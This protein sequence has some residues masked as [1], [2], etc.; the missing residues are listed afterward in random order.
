ME[1]EEAGSDGGGDR[2][3][4]VA[5]V[6]TRFLRFGSHR[7]FL[8]PRD[9]ETIG[10]WWSCGIP[11]SVVLLGLDEAYLARLRRV[12]SRKRQPRSIDFAVR[13]VDRAWEAY[14]ELQVGKPG[15]RAQKTPSRGQIKKGAVSRL[16]EALGHARDLATSR[17]DGWLVSFLADVQVTIEKRPAAESVFDAESYLDEA[18]ERLDRL[19]LDSLSASTVLD[20]R[21]RA[22]RDLEGYTTDPHFERYVDR[23]AAA[24]LREE[25]PLPLLTVL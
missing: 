4:Y 20:A 2:E 21:H 10:E 18:M 14:R 12:R 3:R 7:L 11:A 15:G 1:R 24:T 19:L 22:R 23:M 25:Y 5:L 6:A 17:G 8:S 13:Q 9:Y 16:A